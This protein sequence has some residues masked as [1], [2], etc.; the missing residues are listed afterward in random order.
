MEYYNK[1]NQR[2]RNNQNKRD[3][4]KGQGRANDKY[5]P[6]K[7]IYTDTKR[8]FHMQKITPAKSILYGVDLIELGKLEPNENVPKITIENADTF[9]MAIEFCAEGLNPLV[10]NMASNFKPGGGVASGKT[11]QEECLF[12]RSNAFMTHPHKWYPLGMN[13]VIY[14]PEVHIIKD[15]K[16]EMLTKSARCTVGMI[17]VAA[18]RNPTL[19]NGSATTGGVYNPRGYSTMVMKIESIFKTAIYHG[20][21]SLVLGALGCG[22]FKNPPK[23]VAEIFKQ[24]VD[25]YGWYFK[26]IGF[27][28][29]VVRDKDKTNLA[30]FEEIIKIK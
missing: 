15:S 7:A 9:D 5:G 19:S 8:Y 27:A 30:M 6:M 23:Q 10:L 17:A 25:K 1:K 24:M 26:K 4:Y 29:L 22:V 12:R 3:K 16:Y 14:S 13:D 20:H 18:L 11:A 28:I 21:D 2:R